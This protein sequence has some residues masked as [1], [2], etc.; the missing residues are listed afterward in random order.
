[1]ADAQLVAQLKLDA[2]QYNQ[3]MKRATEA[4]KSATSSIDSVSSEINKVSLNSNQAAA[5]VKSLTSAVIG[6]VSVQKLIAAS[7][8]WTTLN[9]RIRLVTST[10][11]EFAAAQSSLVSISQGTGQALNSIG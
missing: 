6:Y 11:A 7:D 1:M 10:Q 8:E 3:E 5:S 4:A 9:N 2:T